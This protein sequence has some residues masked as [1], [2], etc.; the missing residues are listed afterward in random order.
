[1]MTPSTR[2]TS[3]P[4]LAL[5]LGLALGACDSDAPDL[6]LD[7][8]VSFR[9]GDGTWGPG[10]LNTNFLGLDQTL[11]VDGVPLTDDADA[12]VR[13][14]AVWAKRCRD[15]SSGA[16]LEGLFYTS[17]LDGD[18]A[19]KVVDGTLQSATFRRYGDPAVTCTVDGHDWVG[20]IWGL[21][22]RDGEG[23]TH[24]RYMMLVSIDKDAAGVSLYRWGFFDEGDDLWSPKLYKPTCLED[25]DPYGDAFVYRYHAYLVEDLEVSATGEFT[26]TSS[27][28]FIA[29]RSGA[30]GKAIHWGYDPAT[31]GTEVHELAT[32]VVR[33]DYCG[34]G[35][36][37]TFAGNAVQVRDA[38]GINDFDAVPLADE[39]AW[40]LDLGRA[41]CVTLP[42]E[43]TLRPNFQGI[44]CD[45][46]T[47]STCSSATMNAATI[48]TKVAD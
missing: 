14:H 10:K 4:A 36:S 48:A 30:I 7:A 43:H 44:Q 13:L 16:I 29:C 20:T 25:K 31:W 34:D 21:I 9:G 17:D 46:F 6:D 35:E 41:T 1:M 37:Y 47:L 11:P 28:F 24:N 15:R 18:L 12:D 45:G 38:L 33:A 40:S 3:I 32:R 26:S 5:A 39:A 8:P 22:V 19:V 27:T 23:V 2:T 42:R